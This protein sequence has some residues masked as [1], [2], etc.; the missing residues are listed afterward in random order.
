M[1][2]VR[3]TAVKNPV[4]YCFI[5]SPLWLKSLN[6]LAIDKRTRNQHNL[7]YVYA[8]IIHCGSEGEDVYNLVIYVPGM[9]NPSQFNNLLALRP[10]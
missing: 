4:K 5:L 6:N 8:V 7:N 2:D 9:D 10:P 3:H 1:Q